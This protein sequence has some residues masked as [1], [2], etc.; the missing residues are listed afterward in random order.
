MGNK[1]DSDRFSKLLLELDKFNNILNSDES[2]LAEKVSA[3]IENQ[4]E[5]LTTTV[6]FAIEIYKKVGTNNV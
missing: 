6:H 2:T 5:T 4:L 1:E 3:E